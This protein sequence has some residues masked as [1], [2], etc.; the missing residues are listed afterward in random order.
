MSLTQFARP[1]TL[2]LRLL[3][4]PLLAL[5]LAFCLRQYDELLLARYALWI[6]SAGPQH[7]LFA[8]DVSSTYPPTFCPPF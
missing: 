8:T 7:S 6:P 1:L 3:H 5:L 4:L 2:E